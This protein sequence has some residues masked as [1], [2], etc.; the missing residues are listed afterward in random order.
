MKFYEGQS[1]TFDGQPVLY[2]VCCA[3]ELQTGMD[4]PPTYAYHIKHYDTGKQ[5]W[6]GELY[7]TEDSL[8]A[9]PA[10]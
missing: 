4:T 8:K 5:E 1:V 2:R 3:K 9:V 6:V 7:V 10:E